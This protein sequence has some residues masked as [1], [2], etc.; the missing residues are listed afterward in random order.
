MSEAE[1]IAGDNPIVGW[2]TTSDGQH[3]PIH[4]DGVRVSL[5]VKEDDCAED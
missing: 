5:P 1:Q 3:V 2:G 4:K